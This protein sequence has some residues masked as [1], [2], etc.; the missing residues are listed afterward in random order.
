[1]S[2]AGVPMFYA[3][4]DE[5]TAFAETFTN[6]PEKSSVTF[7]IFQALRELRLLDLTDI[8]AVPSIFDEEAATVRSALGFIK[9]FELDVTA[10][11][12]ND[13]SVHYLYVPTQVVAEYFRHVFTLPDESKLDGIVFNSS[14][15]PG[16]KCYTL[17]ADT[18]QCTDS[19]S[20]TSKLL[21]L[22]SSR[23]TRID[24]TNG[25]FS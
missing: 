22:V 18:N 9:S 21:A 4:G 19:L 8:P 15:R 7:A 12:P 24:F 3:T 20:D 13:Y 11:I 17:F 1:M 10:P 25:T 23:K 16:G 2:P 6:N 5:A 14:R